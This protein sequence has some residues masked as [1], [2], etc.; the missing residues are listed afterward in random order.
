MGA[1]ISSGPPNIGKYDKA[2]PATTKS[3]C[4]Q[5]VSQMDLLK[6]ELEVEVVKHSGFS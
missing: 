4:H 3:Y 1:F 5:S 6:R 2:L